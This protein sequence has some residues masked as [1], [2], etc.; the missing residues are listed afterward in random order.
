MPN[1]PNY[2]ESTIVGTTWLRCHHCTIQN[3]LNLPPLEYGVSSLT[4]GEEWVTNT[5][6]RV[7]KEFAGQGL[8]CTFDETDPDDLMLY[9]LIN[10]KYIKLRGARDNA[11][12]N[13]L[14]DSL[15]PPV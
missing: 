12:L 1:T 5:G 6:T 2:K 7:I 8:T 13:P 4:L 14:P 3:P 10:K 9:T 11:L 15:L